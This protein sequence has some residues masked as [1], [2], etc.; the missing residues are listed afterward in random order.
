MP[1]KETSVSC[2][3]NLS[4]DYS[5]SLKLDNYVKEDTNYVSI[6]VKLANTS[7]EN[8][9]D[10]SIN[11]SNIKIFINDKFV[12]L[13]QLYLDFTKNP[14]YLVGYNYSIQNT[15]TKIITIKASLEVDNDSNYI[16]NTEIQ[17][18]I[19]LRKIYK[20]T[21][22]INISAVQMTDCFIDVLAKTT[23]DFDLIEYKINTEDWK[24]YTDVFRVYKIPRKQF[25][26]ARIK[27]DRYLLL[28]KCYQIRL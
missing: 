8:Q 25:I 6:I 2:N 23:S 12:K 26:Q 27:Q 24:P 20:S 28:L 17:D 15:D 13:V 10:L 18:S 16:T 19:A 3:G 22:S 4:K 14:Y 1:V 11:K 9:V 7:K 21:P 5:L